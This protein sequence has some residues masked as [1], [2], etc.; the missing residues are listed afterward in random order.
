MFLLRN[1]LLMFHLKN[2]VLRLILYLK[3]VGGEIWGPSI[4]TLL[5]QET[6]I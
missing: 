6:G 1:F 3:Y 5:S 2:Y 4:R